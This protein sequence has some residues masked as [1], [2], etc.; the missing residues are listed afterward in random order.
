MVE[1]EARATSFGSVAELYEQGRP[2]YPAAA[3]EWML[4]PVRGTAASPRVLDV[5][6]GTGKL[7]RGLAAAGCRVTAVD[8]DA[9]M[10][11]QLR[12]SVP[13][14]P[15]G[16][17]TAES[18]PCADASADAV[19]LGQAWHWVDPVLASREIARVLR[20]GGVLG[21]VWNLRD[22]RTAWAAEL[23]ALVRSSGSRDT[24]AAGGPELAPPFGAPEHAS[25]AWEH[26]ATRA[27]LGGMLRSRSSYIT[28][29][30]VERAELDAGLARILDGL[31]L[32][33]GESIGMP[34]VTHAFR[35]ILPG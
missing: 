24:M 26:P 8:P 2:E 6:A 19:V 14:V 12:G 30:P 7:S 17:G 15:T 4:A 11:E 31:G 16:I 18:L 13:G 5:G 27:T 9:Q 28:G 3:I 29:S 32:R 1:Q 10:L 33:D 34:Y 35:A 25:W 20:P 21:L 23:E 22:P